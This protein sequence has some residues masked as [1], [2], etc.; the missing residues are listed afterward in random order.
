METGK[1][2]SDEKGED[3]TIIFDPGLYYLPPGPLT[4]EQKD[5]ITDALVECMAEINEIYSK[6]EIIERQI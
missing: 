4:E 1:K 2:A 3:R 5:K 6:I